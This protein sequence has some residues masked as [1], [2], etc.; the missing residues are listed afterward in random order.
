MRSIPVVAALVLLSVAC[1]KK[2]GD[3]GQAVALGPSPTPTAVN[4]E[5][6]ASNLLRIGIDQTYSA[7]VQWSN[8]TSTTQSAAWRSDA[9]QVATID[10]AGHARALGAGEAT[11]VA[12]YQNVEGKLRI[13]VVPNYHGVW[14]GTAALRT[15]REN[16]GWLESHLCDELRSFGDLQSTLDV[17]QE[18]DRLSGMFTVDDVDA[19]IDSGA[20]RID[21]SASFT[22]RKSEIVDGL[23][24]N[25]V[26]DPVELRSNGDTIA[27]TFTMTASSPAVSGD[28]RAE[29][30]ASQL[31][32][33]GNGL[34]L[35][36]RPRTG[37]LWTL[38]TPR[39]ATN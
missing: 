25:V 10:N 31:A 4:I 1:D 33:G 38:F 20:I 5:P 18:G 27:A 32:R 12:A 2:S 21:G 30:E 26:F 23:T 24:L 19:T 14:H 36:A 7:T 3:G 35:Q 6:Q 15:C 29:F 8:G 28:V 9:P 11:L 17:T 37:G 39:R 34:Q 16:A 13:R 22:A